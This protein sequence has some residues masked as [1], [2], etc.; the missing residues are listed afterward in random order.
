VKP[1]L[2]P[3]L[4]GSRPGTVLVPQGALVR[5]PAFLIDTFLASLVAAVILGG[6]ASLIKIVLVTLAVEFVYFSVC[7]GVLG[8]TL[9]KRLFGLRVVRASDGRPC[10]PLA[11]VVRTLLRLVDNILF[12]LPGITAIVSSPRRQRLGD[13]AAKTLVVSEVPEQLLKAISGFT[14]A[15]AFDPEHMAKQLNALAGRHQAMREPSVVV[16]PGGAAVPGTA[17]DDEALRVS[18]LKDVVPCP[19]CGEQMSADE[20]VCGQCDHYV[21][22]VSAH[23]ETDA[24]APIPQ[25]YSADRNLRFDALWQLVFAADE[26]SLAAVREAVPNWPRAD[27]LLAVHAFS[28]VGDPR[29][30]AFLEFMMQDPDAAVVALARDVRERLG[31]SV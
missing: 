9:G 27:R 10:G 14:G 3:H 1:Q 31:A 15:G 20:I 12:S 6:Q 16:G 29:P 26:E 11:A 19:F 7:E 25:L 21:N 28:E 8:T 17:A 2:Q 24:M 30:V 23:G 5:G 18:V 22:Q 4:A 13:R